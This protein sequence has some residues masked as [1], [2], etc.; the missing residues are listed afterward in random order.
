MAG[1]RFTIPGL[2]FYIW[3]FLRYDKKPMLSD[4]RNA[5]LPGI[6]MF[7]GGNGALTLAEQFIPSGFA[8]L[9]IST[10]PLW[11]VLL[12]WLFFAKNKPDTQTLLGIGLGIIGVALLARIDNT[13]L[14][15]TAKEG[16]S[17]PLGV[18]MLIF[19]SIS[20]A[21]GSLFSR[22]M[23]SD[24]SLPFS[25]SM[26]ILSGGIVLLFIGL[27]KGEAKDLAFERISLLSLG[28]MIYLILMG[29]LLA[30]SAYIWL[31]RVS[32]PAKV[33][34]YAFFNPMVALFLG[35]L[36]ADE[37]ITSQTIIGAVLIL[38]SILLVLKP[39]TTD[40]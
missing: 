38:G 28:S 25:I 1:M 36:L 7:V 22:N 16:T 20:W 29:T 26:K 8:S 11:M 6:L 21:T 40:G 13:I 9:I 30:Y 4:W 23:K 15:E 37:M 31:L 14:I 24:I 12:D 18:I 5:A 17:V 27:V 35:W 10:I 2:F 32:T 3:C 19:A 33:S 34:T 39:K